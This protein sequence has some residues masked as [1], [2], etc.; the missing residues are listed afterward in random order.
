MTKIKSLRDIPSVEELT[1][2]YLAESS[3]SNIPRP[4]VVLAAQSVLE[5]LREAMK[6]RE[7][8]VTLA[9]LHE[10]VHAQLYGQLRAS[11]T[12]VINATGV[13]IHTNLGRA[14]LS[15]EIWNEVGELMTG[16]CN[17]EFDLAG[18][19]RGTRGA[20]C[21]SYLA[22]LAQA[23]AATIVNNNT[24]ALMLIF[25]SFANRKQIIISRGE[26]LQIGGGFRIPDLL[27]RSGAKLVEVGTTNITTI[28]DYE[29]AIGK[30]TALLLKVHRSNFLQ[31]GFTDTV[32]P[33]VL[34][35]LAK[36]H[37]LLF[38]NDLGSGAFISTKQMA[39]YEEPTVQRSVQEGADLTCFSGDKLLGGSQAGLIVGKEVSIA[40]LK[41]NPLF[42]A[43]RVDKI[44]FA[45]LERLFA[46]YLNNRAGED[47][48]LWQ[49]LAVPESELYK[50]AKHIVNQVGEP[51][52][53]SVEAT[54]A[55]LGGGTSPEAA[56]PSVAI[57]FGRNFPVNKLQK[58]FR[59]LLL[60]IIGRIEGDRFFLDLKVVP[61]SDDAT[62]IESIRTV[63]A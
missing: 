44:T 48:P 10:R 2:F 50:R 49:M 34:A 21:E 59:S 26:L 53:V 22:T 33:S 4:Q 27:V 61:I 52:G 43:L 25:N 1:A 12:R 62:L 42:R 39:G 46:S 23:E 51:S 5:E 56:V 57:I 19:E 38:V 8:A 36:K 41:K 58:Q 37:D 17:L 54:R 45:L 35:S 47:I 11:L 18:G 24:A 9:H 32:P 55:L 60:P 7:Q 30:Q 63:L 16:Y 40:K 6:E 13:V 14:P 29:Q 15:P 31:S 28:E 20:V 3:M